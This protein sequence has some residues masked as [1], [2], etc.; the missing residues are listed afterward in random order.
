MRGLVY[1]V[2]DTGDIIEYIYVNDSFAEG[3]RGVAPEA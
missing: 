1:R 3:V 2:I